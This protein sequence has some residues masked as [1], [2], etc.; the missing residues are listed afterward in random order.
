VVG[1]ENE[2]VP[3]YGVAFQ[4]RCA[5]HGHVPEHI[6]PDYAYAADAWGDAAKKGARDDGRQHQ[7]PPQAPPQAAR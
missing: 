3:G 5:E 4:N 7:A 6:E 2:A 1:C